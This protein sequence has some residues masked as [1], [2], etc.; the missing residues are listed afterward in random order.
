M[1][2]LK[3][4]KEK[5]SVLL[6]SMIML[7]VLTLLVVF[8]IR[9]GNTNL[10][11]AGNM[12]SQAEAAAATQQVIEQVIEQ[13]KVADNIGSIPAQTVPVSMGGATYNV[14][15]APMNK[16]LME[17]PILNAD[18]NP[19]VAEDVPCFENPDTDQAIKAD[20]SMTTKPSACKTQQ[21]DIEAG[22]TDGASGAKVTQVQGIT[23]RVPATVTCL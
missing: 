17:V 22:V 2:S 10:R 4:H 14:V 20:G 12:Q 8:A 16:C 3:K 19:S 21:W 18:L 1:N 5:G 13:I 9:S 7:V 11:I 15:T 6:V 23:I